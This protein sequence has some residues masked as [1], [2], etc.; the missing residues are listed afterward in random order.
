M[1]KNIPTK[2]NSE[3][4][5]RVLKSLIE[6][7]G[8][9][10]LNDPKRVRALLS[11]HCVGE[12]K[13]QIIVIERLLE[14]NIH[15]E[16]LKQKDTIAYELLSSNL[17]LRILANHPF[18]KSLVTDG[19]DNL[20]FVLDIITIH[21]LRHKQNLPKDS[22]NTTTS[23]PELIEDVIRLN[24]SKSFSDALKLLEQ[25]LKRD[26]ENPVALREKAYAVSNL[27]MYKE[28]LHWFN[29]SIRRNPDDPVT[30]IQKGYALSKIGKNSDAVY[31]YDAA[32]KLDPEGAV[33]WRNRGFSLRKLKKYPEALQSYENALRIN[34]QDPIAWKLKGGVLGLMKRYNEAFQATQRALDLDPNYSEAMNNMGWLHSDLARYPEAI[35]WYDKA[36]KAEP[37]NQRAWKQRAYCLKKLKGTESK[38][39]P[40]NYKHYY[41]P[42]TS[43]PTPENQGI[44]DKIKDI[45][46]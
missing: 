37:D 19:I 42:R 29:E 21:P 33:V 36:L 13:R 34:P 39:K 31:C 5:K 3:C 30:W 45:F 17:A 7:E 40:N 6:T 12:M 44:F 43:A 27:G 11:D 32:I 46:K 20:A 25:V 18:D 1:S 38:K 15:H 4:I 10:L 23:S 35:T 2:E 41:P 22:R 8:N 16:L 24:Q 14:E 26:P 9:E 28:S